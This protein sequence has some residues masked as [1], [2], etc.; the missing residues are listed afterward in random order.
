[1]LVLD[2][3]TI[4]LKDRHLLTLDVS[5]APGEIFSVMGPSGAGKSS[6]L[7]FVGGFLDPAFT[8]SGRVLLGGRDVTALPPE[9]RGIGLLFQDALLFPHFSVGENLVFGLSPVVKGRARRRAEAEAM[10]ARIGLAGAFDRDPATLS[11]GEA[12]RVAL[13]RTLLAAPKALLLD[14]AFSRLDTAL[15]ESVRGIVFTMIRETGIPAILVTHDRADAEAAGGAVF[16]LGTG[17]I[18][19]AFSASRSGTPVMR[20]GR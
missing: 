9:A 16:D 4:A 5:I 17:E 19:G 18:T 3:L 6:L 13:G 7:A 12:A 10:L 1:M 2:A 8:G 14:E 15:R 20:A 11:G